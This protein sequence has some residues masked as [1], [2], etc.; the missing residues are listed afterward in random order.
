MAEKFLSADDVKGLVSDAVAD[1]IKAVNTVDEE[2]RPSA[3]KAFN[4]TKR[5]YGMPKV[6]AAMKAAFRG[7]FNGKTD[8]YEKDFTQ[9]AAALFGYAGGE[10]APSSRSV[11]W[12]KNMQEA[13]QVFEAMGE[14]KHADLVHTAIKANAEGTTGAGGAL[15]PPQY[16][17]EAFAYALVPG[18]VVRNLPGVSVMPVK[19]GTTVYLPRES[20]RAGAASTAEAGSLTN[21]DVTFAQQSI[22]LKKQYGYR[23]FS[24]ELLAD[25]DPAWA[26]F[27]TTTLLRDVALYQDQQY[28]EGAGTGN[29]ITGLASY[30]GTTAGP[31]PGTV[32]NGTNGGTLNFDNLYD[33]IYN[34][35]VNNV[36]PQQ[37]SG[38]IICHPRTLNSLAKI[39]DT[40]GNYILSTS[41]GYNAPALFGG[42]IPGNANGP[43]AMVMGIPVYLTS[44]IGI[45]NT[46]GTSTDCS[47]LYIGDASKIVIL[48]R[49][50]IE[51]AFSDQVGFATDQSAY[52]AIARSALAVIQPTA[53]EV[54]NGVRG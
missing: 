44:Q 20:V 41:Q 22:T 53:V 43:R 29:F 21:Q 26:Q 49:Q 32:A 38:F 50:G 17:Q 31:V 48:E 10:E 5:S 28:L 25:A 33:A 15:V 45:A 34:L 23:V 52:R 2:S 16:L 14:S 24:N 12:P 18:I 9:T 11:V 37:G 27:I 40:T 36:E 42:Q 46:V 35:R 51:L 7:G 19:T 39:K 8:E 1:A 6:G 13:A 30:S 54:I 3:P 4:I 47:N